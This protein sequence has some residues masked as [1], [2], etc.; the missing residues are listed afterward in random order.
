MYPFGRATGIS[1]QS[2][3][4]QIKNIH[5]LF[6]PG[7]LLGPSTLLLLWKNQEENVLSSEMWILSFK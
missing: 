1:A 4:Q 6:S 5:S 7:S 3:R 2:D